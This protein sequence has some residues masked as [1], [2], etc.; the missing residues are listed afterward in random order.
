MT[1]KLRDW[2]SG[3]PGGCANAKDRCG[4]VDRTSHRLGGRDRLRPPWGRDQW[5]IEGLRRNEQKIRFILEQRLD[6]A[7]WA[8]AC[9]GLGIRVDKCDELEEA[10]SQALGF[11]DKLSELKS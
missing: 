8:E 11:R 4:G 2:L 3:C 5:V 6:F 1:P 9:G 10:V 7:P